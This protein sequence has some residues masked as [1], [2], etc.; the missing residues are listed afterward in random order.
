MI[1]KVMPCHRKLV[2]YFT[3][4]FDAAVAAEA[5]AAAIAAAAAA[6]AAAAGN[7]V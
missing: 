7:I 3:E 5:A 2:A 1:E 4:L 6:A